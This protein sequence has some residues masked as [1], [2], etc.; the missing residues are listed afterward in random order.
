MTRESAE[1]VSLGLLVVDS[2]LKEGRV[3]LTQP[4][5]LSVW[6]EVVKEA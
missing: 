3:M 6:W 4:S 2:P 5:M 1:L